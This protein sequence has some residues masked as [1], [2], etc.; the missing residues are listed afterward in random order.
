MQST[1]ITAQST[2]RTRKWGASTRMISRFSSARE[3]AWVTVR[4]CAAPPT[5]KMRPNVRSQP[6]RLLYTKWA[7]KSSLARKANG[8]SESSRVGTHTNANTCIR[9]SFHT[10]RKPTKVAAGQQPI[11][12]IELGVGGL[13]PRREKREG[14]ALDNARECQ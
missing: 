1:T 9:Y 10:V 11:R 7:M 5:T 4:I 8:T 2:A 13:D 12:R 6:R 14:N 3:R